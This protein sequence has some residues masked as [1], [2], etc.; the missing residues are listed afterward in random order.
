[1]SKIPY[2]LKV[3]AIRTTKR[4]STKVDKVSWKG[5]TLSHVKYRQNNVTFLRLIFHLEC[6]AKVEILP[7][8]TPAEG[9]LGRK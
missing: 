5:K 6:V 4:N 3:S 9:R 8:T 2:P 1:M 7:T